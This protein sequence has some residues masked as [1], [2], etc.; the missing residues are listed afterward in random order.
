MKIKNTANKKLCE[1][2][3]ELGQDIEDQSYPDDISGTKEGL[4]KLRN[5]VG[6]WLDK[7]RAY[8]T[9]NKAK[10]K[11]LLQGI[12]GIEARYEIM[13]EKMTEYEKTPEYKESLREDRQDY[14]EFATDT[15]AEFSRELDIIGHGLKEFIKNFQ[16]LIAASEAFERAA[17]KTK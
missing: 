12:T 1:R 3:E 5:E 9:A 15:E 10:E 14:G 2:L 4:K 11:E 13:T 7:N 6:I 17:Q 16:S 8:L